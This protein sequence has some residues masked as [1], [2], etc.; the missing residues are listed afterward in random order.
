MVKYS[1]R[2]DVIRPLAAIKPK[3]LFYLLY[4]VWL[5]Y[6]SEPSRQSPDLLGKL[7]GCDLSRQ[8]AH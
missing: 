2:P 6:D 4:V 3:P 1:K 8:F 7:S 5:L